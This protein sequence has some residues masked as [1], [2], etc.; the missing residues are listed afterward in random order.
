[1]GQTCHGG[2]NETMMPQFGMNAKFQP[3]PRL[4]LKLRRLG[5]LP[6]RPAFDRVQARP[7]PL[8]S[9]FLAATTGL[10]VGGGK[11]QGAGS[12]GATA[13]AR[14]KNIRARRCI[15]WQFPGDFLII[16]FAFRDASSHVRPMPPAKLR[17]SC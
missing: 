3:D 4:Y 15:G 11:R 5:P 10:P 9:Y 14:L 8:P 7:R 6:A 17:H 13:A 2:L 12:A 16:F 1:M